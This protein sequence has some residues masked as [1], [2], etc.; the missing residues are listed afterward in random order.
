MPFLW[1]KTDDWT[2]AKVKSTY[3][4][5]S[6]RGGQFTLAVLILC[7]LL[8]FSE[9][10]TWWVGSETHHFS[11]ERGVGWPRFRVMQRRA[12][13]FE[14]CGPCREPQRDAPNV[15]LHR[16]SLSEGCSVVGVAVVRRGGGDEGR[17]DREIERHERPRA[18]R[19]KRDRRDA[20]RA[21]VRP[22]R[23]RA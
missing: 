9:L 4:A 2:L 21:A 23:A 3:T 13:C 14:C 6:A 19:C 11:V 17:S 10:K 20:G 15:R 16:T 22:H 7:T 8:T 18:A 5:P 12:E 1:T